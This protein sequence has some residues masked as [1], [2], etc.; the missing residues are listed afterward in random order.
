[1][2]AL[3]IELF[4]LFEIRSRKEVSHVEVNTNLEGLEKC[5]DK[6]SIR[7]VMPLISY[8]AAPRSE[9]PEALPI[10]VR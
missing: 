10:R 3:M 5:Y 2:V 9:T 6:K 1:V 8:P 7:Q 4:K